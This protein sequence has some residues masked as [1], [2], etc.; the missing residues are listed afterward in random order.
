[1]AIE[2]YRQAEVRSDAADWEICH[3]MGV[4][5]MYLKELEQAKEELMRA[6]HTHKNEQSYMTLGKILVMQGDLKG[7]MDT[8]KQGVQ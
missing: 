1:M 7:A 5:H 2:A 3:N 4:C 6:I 8:Y